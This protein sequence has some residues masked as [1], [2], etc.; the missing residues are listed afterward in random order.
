LSDKSS[1][2]SDHQAFTCRFH[3]RKLHLLQL[4]DL[5]HTTDLGQQAVKQP[6]IPARDADDGGDALLIGDTAVGMRAGAKLG[7]SAP[8]ERRSAAE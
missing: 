7:H 6:E 2:G 8:R 3:H 4:V 1:L 5:Q